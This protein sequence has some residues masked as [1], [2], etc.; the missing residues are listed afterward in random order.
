MGVHILGCTKRTCTGRP[1]AHV[2][3][4]GLGYLLEPMFLVRGL[5][6]SC[7]SSCSLGVFFEFLSLLEDFFGS[8]LGDFF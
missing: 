2:G 5:E 7:L 4:M 8:I 6:L 3:S 1:Y